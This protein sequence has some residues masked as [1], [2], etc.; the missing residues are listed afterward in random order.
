MWI[1]IF[2]TSQTDWDS[3]VVPDL[4]S[5]IRDV[6]LVRRILVQ[7]NP[8]GAGILEWGGNG[9]GMGRGWKWGDQLMT[10][11]GPRWMGSYHIKEGFQVSK[12]NGR[13]AKGKQKARGLR[14]NC[15]PTYTCTYI[16]IAWLLNVVN[17]H[18]RVQGAIGKSAQLVI[19]Q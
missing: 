2:C 17:N 1:M 3:I 11:L 9:E 8:R 5:R 7:E 16:L 14:Q 12:R 19:F 18:D 13:E 6:I 10:N 4:V 15:V